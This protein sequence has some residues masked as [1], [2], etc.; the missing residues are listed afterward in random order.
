MTIKLYKDI[1]SGLW[2]FSFKGKTYLITNGSLM[3]DELAKFFKKDF[4]YI[5]LKPNGLQVDDF[6][7]YQIADWFYP[8]NKLVT[9]YMLINIRWQAIEV[10]EID[11]PVN[12]KIIDIW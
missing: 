10:F 12:F 8:T 9:F 11:K 5:Q 7:Y 6:G 2:C 3:I 1:N 4:L